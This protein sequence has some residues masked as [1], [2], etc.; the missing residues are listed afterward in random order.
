MLRELAKAAILF[1]IMSTI[2]LISGADAQPGQAGPIAIVIHGGAG[3]ILPGQMDSE[4]EQQYREKLTEAVTAGYSVLKQNGTSLDA[5]TAA[6]QIME[7]SPLFNAGKGS[8]LTNAG[9]VEMD[10][11]IMDGQ[12]HRAGAVARIMHVKNP[13]ALARLVMEDSPH[14]MMVGDGAEAFAE[15]HGVEL[16]PNEYFQTDR[17]RRQLLQT[18]EEE[19]R[20]RSTGM[21]VRQN[22]EMN[23]MRKYG[24]VG[25]V[26]LDHDGNIAAAT[27]TGGMTN[28]RFGR[29]GDSPI[30]GAGTYADN[31]TCGVSST[32][33]GEYFM[34]GVIA[35]DISAMMRYAHL[36]LAEAANAVIHGKLTEMGGTGGVIALDREGHIVTPFNT[37]GMFRAY[38]DAE[39][40]TV[41]KMYRNEGE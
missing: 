15:E 29:V 21:R 26:A 38:I 6:I 18:Q 33:Y 30:I 17:R 28:K 25:A 10:A 13:I 27:S 41:V 34:R 12:T 36:P 9:T 3:S 37:D 20:E 16:V 39:G 8:V 40:T 31:E 14:V 19:S 11:S 1:A 35:Y 24:T 5:V 32:G 22:P 23:G 7:D 4:Q 2:G